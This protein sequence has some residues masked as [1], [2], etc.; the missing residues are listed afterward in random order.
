MRIIASLAALC[1][2][3]MSAGWAQTGIHETEQAD[4]R[5]E[6][7]A[8]GLEFPWSIA[9]LP[10]GDML[11]SEREGRLRLIDDGVLRDAPITGLPDMLVSRQGGLLGLAL[12]P[13]FDSN[14]LVYFAFSEGRIN[15]NH[16][17]LARGRLSDDATALET[18]E[19]LFRVNFDKARGLHFGGRIQFIA[20]GTLLLTLGEGGL[21]PNEAQNLANHLGSVV[22]LNDDGTVPFDNPFVSVRGAGPE[23]YTYGH[24]NVQGI[25][26]NP[27]TGSVWTHE[28]GARGGDEINII[29]AGNNYG[30]PR[31]TWGIDYDG[32]PI[33]DATHGDGLEQPIWFWDPSIAP[34]GMAFY[35]GEGFERWQGD[36]FIGALAGSRL[37]RMEVDGDRVI[38]SED[39]L[40]DRGDRIRDVASGP[41]GH[42][43]ILTDSDE[44]A[45]LRL[46]PVI[47]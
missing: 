10:D 6:T 45:V 9:F 33:S 23:I 14:R 29:E 32:T 11:V 16:T 3:T 25:A 46:V 34:S 4:F 30:W 21:H 47:P 17:A 13:E 42:L 35:E 20:D 5:V 7:V 2:A 24:R 19:T 39:L 40:V 1:A 36:V 28:H 43:Y 15:A 37:V 12:H 18:V 38:S 44:G 31:I 41:D 26:I 8:E 22:R 27:Q